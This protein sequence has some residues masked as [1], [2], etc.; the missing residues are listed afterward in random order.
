MGSGGGMITA[1]LAGGLDASRSFLESVNL[2]TL[3][4]SLGG[5][6]ALIEHPAIMTHASVPAADG[7]RWGST[8]DWTV[9][10]CGIEEAEDLLEDVDHA[11]GKIS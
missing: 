4:E 1:T 9:V 10:L 6:K 11:L 8:M 5:V 7:R 2:F 3:A